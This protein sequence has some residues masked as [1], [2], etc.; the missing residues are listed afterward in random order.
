MFTSA[1]VLI[2][3]YWNVNRLDVIIPACTVTV[4]ISTYWNVNSA[5]GTV[6]IDTN[7]VLISTYWNVNVYSGNAFRGQCRRFNLNLLE[8]KFFLM[9][10]D[11]GISLCFNLNLL[12]CK[13]CCE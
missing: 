4:L 2:S 1:V 6:I 8:C 13:C 7:G 9:R 3:T 10:S 12:E 11:N 5:S